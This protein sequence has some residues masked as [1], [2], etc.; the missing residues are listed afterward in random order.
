MLKMAKIKKNISIFKMPVHQ[1]DEDLKVK[2]QKLINNK[3]IKQYQIEL[4][5]SCYYLSRVRP[6]QK[7]RASPF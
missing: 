6:N 2:I 5:K 4:N 3:G 7:L 1:S